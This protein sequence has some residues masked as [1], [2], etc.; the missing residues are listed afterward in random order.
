MKLVRV[1]VIGG[2]LASACACSSTKAGPDQLA[3]VSATAKAAFAPRIADPCKLLTQGEASEA[4]GAK[5]Q[6]GELKRFGPITRCEFYSKPDSEQSLLLDVRN[7]T[8]Q[9]SE[10]TLFDSDTHNPDAKSVPGVGDQAFWF[11]SELGSLLE[12]FKAG[13]LVSVT[14]PRT[15]T[16]ATPALGKAARLIASRM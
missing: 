10:A 15:M 8:S 5:L 11:H 2:A 1:M 3:G 16:T 14:L 6:A 9:V 4:I 7:E 13:R 12:I